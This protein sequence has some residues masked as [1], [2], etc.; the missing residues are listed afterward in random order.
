MEQGNLSIR[1]DRS[2]ISRTGDLRWPA[3][4]PDLTAPDYFFWGFLKLKVYVNKPQTIQHLKDNIRHEIEEIQPHILQ[5]AMK[6]DLK[7]A[8]SCIANRGHYLADI[9]F[10]SK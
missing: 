8:E 10:Q 1:Y 5:D 3:R 4:S 7:R 9:I 6:N 2:L